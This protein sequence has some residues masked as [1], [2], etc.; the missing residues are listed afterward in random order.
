MKHQ[1]PNSRDCHVMA[2][3]QF[4]RLLR[5]LNRLKPPASGEPLSAHTIRVE[6]EPISAISYASD[7]S[8]EFQRYPKLPRNV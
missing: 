8:T 6:V 3:N 4:L 5:G 1:L 7:D 2:A